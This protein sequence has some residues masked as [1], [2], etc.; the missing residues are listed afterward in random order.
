MRI[1]ISRDY[2][3]LTSNVT[4]DGE[5]KINLPLIN[6]VY[7]RGLTLEEMNNIL[8]EEY[9]NFIRYPEVESSIVNHR[10]IKV[11][12]DGAVNNPGIQILKG[13]FS[14]IDEVMSQKNFTGIILKFFYYY[15]KVFDAIRVAGGINQYSNINKI[16]LIRNN[17]LSKGGGKKITI[18]NLE[19]ITKNYSS[20]Q[21]IRIYDGDKINVATL[22]EP[23]DKL[24]GSAI[25]SNLSPRFINIIV[26][27]KV[28]F[29]GEIRIGRSGTLNDALDIAGGVKVLKGKIRH[30]SL[31]S[32]GSIQKNIIKYRRRNK[33]GSKNNPYLKDGDI[34][35]VGDSFL[36]SSSEVIREITSP[37]QGIYS[38]YAIIEALTI[39][40]KYD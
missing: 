32:D 40:F 4:I 38:T 29:P 23:N 20:P 27:G 9:L 36:S 28:N 16:E 15:P 30:I 12:V 2:P 6:R 26:T 35:F 1:I 18:L 33:R 22:D 24:I 8:N 21:N 19:D 14:Q 25:K 5:G 3:E 31:A 13:S 7:V 34:V 37:L 39:N 10:D 17:S 11:L